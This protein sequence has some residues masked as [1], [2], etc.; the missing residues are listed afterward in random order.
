M[1]ISSFVKG[2]LAGFTEDWKVKQEQAKEI[3]K[4]EE[5]AAFE[6]RKRQALLTGK[7]RVQVREENKRKSLKENPSVFAG[8]GR[9]MTGLVGDGKRDKNEPDYLERAKKL[10][11]GL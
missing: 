4:L 6:E 7:F 2:K 11:G 5:A 3:K 8:A 1:G 10:T 9:V